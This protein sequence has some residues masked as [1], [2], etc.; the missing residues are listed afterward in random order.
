MNE[1]QRERGGRLEEGN[2]DERML[3]KEERKSG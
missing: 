3:N 2:A 1:R